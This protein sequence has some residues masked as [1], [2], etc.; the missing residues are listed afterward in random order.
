[1][2]T[3]KAYRSRKK[4]IELAISEF[5]DIAS[6]GPVYICFCCN[7]LW[8]KQSVLNAKKLK[9][10]NPVIHEYLEEKR[11]TDTAEWVCKTCH[12]HLVKNKIPPCAVVNGLVFPQ[13]P[14]FFDLNEL[15]CRFF[16]FFKQFY[17]QDDHLYYLQH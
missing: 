11:R 17:L 3:Q 2:E 5:H 10:L 8:Y 7:Q 15:E 16:F 1:M 13:K 4:P 12:N 9:D 14:T 6:E